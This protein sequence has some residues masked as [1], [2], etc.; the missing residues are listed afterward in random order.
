MIPRIISK[1]VDT[2]VTCKNQLH[3]YAVAIEV[4]K[5]KLMYN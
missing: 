3:F 2:R 4:W 5:A 1:A